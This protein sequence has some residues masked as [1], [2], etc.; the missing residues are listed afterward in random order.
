MNSPTNSSTTRPKPFT[1]NG[2]S[3]G[4][5][6]GPNAAGEWYWRARGSDGAV[7]YTHLTL[8]TSDLV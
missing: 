7:S 3:Y 1:V 5:V 8:P 6:R 4:V 2:L